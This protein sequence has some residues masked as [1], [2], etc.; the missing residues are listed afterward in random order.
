MIIDFHTHCFPAKIAE[1]AMSLLKKESGIAYPYHDGTLGSLRE[2]VLSGTADKAVVLNI[3]TNPRQ[4]KS[5]ND[6]SISLLSEPDV[7]PFGSVHPESEDALTELERLKEAGIKGVK[8]HPEYQKFYVDDKKM[9]PVYKKIAQLGLITVFHA[10]FDIGYL[11]PYHCTPE[12]LAR[13]LEHFD[14]APVVAAHMGGIAEHEGVIKHLCGKDIYF[15]TAFAC[16]SI[17]PVAAREILSLHP[18]DRV[19]LGSDMPWKSTKDS[20]GWVKSLGLNETDEVK[21]LGEN[22][23]KL[24]AL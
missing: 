14:G 16:A 4:Q 2:N 18:V 12:R 5:V 3:A 13:A 6:F 23:E 24:L 10:G 20:I 1:K 21:I 19:L 22:A 8:F 15:D 17:Q 11:P 9:I 7:I